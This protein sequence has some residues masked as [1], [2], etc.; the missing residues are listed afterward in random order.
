MV[1]CDQWQVVRNLLATGSGLSPTALPAF[2]RR[3]QDAGAAR[4]EIAAQSMIRKSG[5]RFSRD[6]REAFAQRSCSEKEGGYDAIA[7]HNRS[8]STYFE[9]GILRSTAVA[10]QLSATVAKNAIAALAIAGNS[11]SNSQYCSHSTIG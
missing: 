5:G 1:T 3:D 10:A 4:G 9:P 2:G 7:H 11:M 8:Y 6:K